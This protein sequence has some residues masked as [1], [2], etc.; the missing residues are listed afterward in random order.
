MFSI[1]VHNWLILIRDTIMC[2]KGKNKSKQLWC[3]MIV[4]IMPNT[5][6]MEKGY[7]YICAFNNNSAILTLQFWM[8]EK[9]IY[10]KYLCL[11]KEFLIEKRN[12]WILALYLASFAVRNFLS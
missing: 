1:F 8:S 6:C 3:S 12:I 11:V 10:V 7:L 2:K 5:L 9:L 4:I